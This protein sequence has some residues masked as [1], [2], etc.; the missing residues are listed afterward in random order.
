MITVF[1]VNHVIT[2]VI[3]TS[4][5]DCWVS[6]WTWQECSKEC[7]GGKQ[8]GTRTILREPLHGGKVCGEL[9]SSRACNTDPCPGKSTLHRARQKGGPQVAWM[10][11]AIPGRQKW[12]A[13]A[14]TKFTKRGGPLFSWAL[15]NNTFL[16]CMLIPFALQG[17]ST[18]LCPGCVKMCWK[19]YVFLP[20]E[21]KQNTTFSPDF[22]RLGKY[23]FEIPCTKILMAKYHY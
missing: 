12:W 4:V 6:G 23:L 22:T 11:Q 5:V 8:L 9:T 16:L 7:G 1:G 3:A 14:P 13:G 2:S 18:R 17:I 20:A 19:N 15:Y 21:G 10:L